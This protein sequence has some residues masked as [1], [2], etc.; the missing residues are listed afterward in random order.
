MKGQKEDIDVEEKKDLKPLRDFWNDP[1]LNKNEKFLRDY[2]L[3]KKF[4]DK[5]YDNDSD[6]DFKV[7][8]SDVDLSEDEENINKQEEFEHKYNFRFEEPDQEFIKR[9][10][11]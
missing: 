9:F 5:N 6:Y 8:D 4:L 7:H 3:N 10:D 11:F 1:N 2:V